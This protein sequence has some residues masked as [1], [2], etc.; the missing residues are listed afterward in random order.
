MIIEIIIHITYG[1]TNLSKS[2]TDCSEEFIGDSP[3]FDRLISASGRTSSTLETVL[4]M[5]MF[6]SPSVIITLGK[7]ELYKKL[8]VLSRIEV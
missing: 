7:N 3:L 1:F 6:C 4:G 5:S 8:L 2:M